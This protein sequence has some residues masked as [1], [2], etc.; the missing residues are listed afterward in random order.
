ST[1]AATSA[2]LSR[3]GPQSL[4]PRSPS[5]TRAPVP[6]GS[7]WIVCGSGPVSNRS[8]PSAAGWLTSGPV[9]ATKCSVAPVGG[10]RPAV[11]DGP[12]PAAALAAPDAAPD[13]APAPPAGTLSDVDAPA[14]AGRCAAAGCRPPVRS[15]PVTG[16]ATAAPTTRPATAIR[17]QRRYATQTTG[18]SHSPGSG[19]TMPDRTAVVAT[20]R[21]ECAPILVSTLWMWQRAVVAAMPRDRASLVVSSPHTSAL[22]T[23]RSRGV[24]NAASRCA[25]LAGRCRGTDTG[26]PI[27][28]HAGTG[29]P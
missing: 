20:S 6:A 14:V 4:S 2:K 28:P 16:T 18:M 26:P 21:R 3:G 24:R 5:H 13:A 12:G 29:L 1:A 11:R 23:C 25:S 27:G 10:G 15:Q 22:S 19:L 9:F 7:A 17:I 8:Y